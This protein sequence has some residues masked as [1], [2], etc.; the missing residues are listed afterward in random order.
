MYKKTVDT[1]C[2]CVRVYSIKEIEG[3]GT[4]HTCILQSKRPQRQP[5]GRQ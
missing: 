5:I 3:D 4:N 1:Y 2:A